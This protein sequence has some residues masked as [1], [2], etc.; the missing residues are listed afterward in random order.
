MIMCHLS[1][2]SYH[3]SFVLSS[4]KKE[5]KEDD[6]LILFHL[7]QGIIGYICGT[8]GMDSSGVSSSAAVSWFFLLIAFVVNDDNELCLYTSM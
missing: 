3:E 5:R 1:L 2:H 8:E 6:L 4:E 7:F